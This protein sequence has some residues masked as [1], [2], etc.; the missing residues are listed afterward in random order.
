[1]MCYKYKKGNTDW[2]CL[3]E[4]I[5]MSANKKSIYECMLYIRPKLIFFLFQEEV[6]ARCDAQDFVNDDT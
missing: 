3:D 1:M 6:P 2:N 4:G 5:L